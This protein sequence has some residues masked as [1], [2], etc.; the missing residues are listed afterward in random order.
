[1]QARRVIVGPP[2]SRTHAL[3]ASA[4]IALIVAAPASA[5]WKP[6]APAWAT[7][8]NMNQLLER[9]Y[10]HAYCDGIPRFGKSGQ[11]PYEKYRVFDCDTRR[12]GVYCVNARWKAVNAKQWGS[13]T[14]KRTVL[15]RCY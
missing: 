14:A 6:G 8:A 12:N 5:V 11:F 1:M 9:Y 3:V 2:M 7:E 10:D 15:P 4:V 13:F